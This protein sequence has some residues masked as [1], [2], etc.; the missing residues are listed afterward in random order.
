MAHIRLNF[1]QFYTSRRFGTAHKFCV[2]C[3]LGDDDLEHMIDCHAFQAEFHRQMNQQNLEL[4]PENLILLSLN[5]L[6]SLSKGYARGATSCV[7]S[8]FVCA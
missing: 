3:E 7:R 4:T 2:V 1:N 8:H 5:F 6:C